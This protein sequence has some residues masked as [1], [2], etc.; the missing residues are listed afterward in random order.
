MFTYKQYNLDIKRDIRLS[1]QLIYG[2]GWL[3]SIFICSRLGF[4]Y[5]FSL[6]NINLYNFFILTYIL[7][8][9]TWLEIRIKRIIFQN[10]K[11][12]YKIESYKGIRHKDSLPVRGQRTR[13]NASTKKRYK[14]IL[15][16]D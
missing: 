12:L 4:S 7:D 11:N 10:I 3:K 13:T 6:N 5:P 9:F 16:T 15:D 8:F 14:I 2:I 1:L